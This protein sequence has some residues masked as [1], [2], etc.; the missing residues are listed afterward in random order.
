[1]GVEATKLGAAPVD[2]IADGAGKLEVGVAAACAKLRVVGGAI[3]ATSNGPAAGGGVG[4]ATGLPTGV[5]V[6]RTGG[7]T[8]SIGV[9]A[10]AV[11]FG[12]PVFTG[13]AAPPAEPAAAVSIF[14]V[15]QPTKIAGTRQ[16][17]AHK[18]TDQ[19][20]F[21]PMPNHPIRETIAPRTTRCGIVGG[22]ADCGNT[23]LPGNR[24]NEAVFAE[25]GRPQVAT[26]CNSGPRLLRRPVD[27]RAF[28]RGSPVC[29]VRRRRRC[30]GACRWRGPQGVRPAD[31][32][33]G[34]YARRRCE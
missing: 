33:R 11:I 26:T 27:A 9:V 8:T 34:A 2:G 21:A 23:D 28:Q 12:T 13:N 32:R 6:A 17:A 25:I 15:E 5:G 7:S 20:N 31:R 4:E 18:T 1:M 3:G 29:K 30:D 14:S 24:T 22:S 10:E 16:I 19:N